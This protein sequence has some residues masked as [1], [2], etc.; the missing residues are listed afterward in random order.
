MKNIVFMLVTFLHNLFTVVWMGGLIVTVI[1][2]L[3]AI[4]E[5]LGPGPQTKKLMKAFQKRQRKWV[6][7]SMAVLILTGLLMSKQS[8]NVDHI[9]SFNTTYGT[10]LSIKHI[11]VVLMIGITLFRT[12]VFGRNQKEMPQQKERMSMMLIL[13]NALLAVFVLFTSA[14]LA[15]L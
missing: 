15:V 3:P 11:L 5:T 2:F 9:F 6:Y 1:S 13:V 12:L 4:K 7:I 14:W 10:I 8:E